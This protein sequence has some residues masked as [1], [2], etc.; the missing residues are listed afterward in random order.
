MREETRS[1]FDAEMTVFK[2]RMLGRNL[3]PPL[4]SPNT[5]QR[6]SV[7]NKSHIVNQLESTSSDR[8]KQTDQSIRMQIG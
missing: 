8:L 4:L 3:P 1:A 2:H 5:W 7:Q 6:Y